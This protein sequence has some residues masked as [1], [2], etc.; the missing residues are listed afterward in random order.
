MRLRQ[1]T[2]HQP[3]TDLPITPREWHPDPEITIKHDDLYARAWQ[4]EYD[5]PIFDSDRDNMV[6]PHSPEVTIQSEKAADKTRS[7][8]ETTRES[9]PEIDLQAD[10]II[11]H[12]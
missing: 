1:F 8:P 5:K 10:N 7:T 3:I 4:C 9:S 11:R 2:P 6:I 12:S